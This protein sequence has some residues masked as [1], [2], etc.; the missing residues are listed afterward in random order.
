MRGP[1]RLAGYDRSNRRKMP[2]IVRRGS[3]LGLVIRMP[4]GTV[5][6]ESSSIGSDR[7]H[8]REFLVASS[9]GCGATLP[10]AVEDL[11]GVVGPVLELLR[12][13]VQV[14]FGHAGVAELVR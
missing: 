7:F 6:A 10:G 1:W 14:L 9:V 12:Y 4:F 13:G 2:T 5:F 8:E 3:R 11:A